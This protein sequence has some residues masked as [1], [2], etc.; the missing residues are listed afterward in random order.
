MFFPNCEPV[1]CSMSGSNCCFL[2]C[3]RVS[4]DAGKVIWYSHHFKNFP[5]IVVIHTIKG[6]NIVNE[7][8]VSLEFPCFFYDP[9]DVGNSISG[10]SVFSK[11]IL[12]I[13]K[14]LVPV[15]L[16]PSLKDLEHYLASMLNE[17]NSVVL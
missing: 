3:I 7:A 15:L 17:C 11:P 4:Q 16:K 12:Y 5:E 8:E 10:S 1:H 14:F 6:F 2:T 13:W 9:T